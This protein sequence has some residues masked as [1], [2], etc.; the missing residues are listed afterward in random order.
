MKRQYVP[1]DTYE[2]LGVGIMAAIDGPVGR[3]GEVMFHQQLTRVVGVVMV[4]AVGVVSSSQDD[5]V[6]DT[7]ISC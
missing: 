3:L 5:I 1:R 6:V 4:R 2:Y 7:T